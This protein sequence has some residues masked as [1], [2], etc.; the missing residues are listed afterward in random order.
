MESNLEKFTNTRKYQNWVTKRELKAERERLAK[1]KGYSEKV[2]DAWLKKAVENASGLTFKMHPITDA[3][4]PD[5]IVH[6]SGFTFYVEVKA[7]G[8]PCTP[9]Q[10]EMHKR[11]HAKGI[12]VYVL[13]TKITHYYD[14]FTSAYTTYEGKHYD[15]NP[16][17]L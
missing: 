6:K 13:D 7:T 14:L 4:L 12:Q 1:A 10:I 2:V 15:K 17:K 8:E 11:I 9:L 16:H 3:G 5:R